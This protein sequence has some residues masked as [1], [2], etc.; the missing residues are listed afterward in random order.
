MTETSTRPGSTRD[1]MI[2]PLI[3]LLA[4]PLIAFNFGFIEVLPGLLATILLVAGLALFRLKTP[5]GPPVD[6]RLLAVCLGVGLV[7]I[8]LSGAGHFLYRTDDWSIRDAVLADLVAHPWPFT[9]QLDDKL[10]MIR[11]PLGMYLVPALAG[12][13][14]GLEAADL[15]MGVQNSLLTGLVLYFF[16][17]EASTWRNRII[18]LVVFLLFHGLSV[19]PEL[20]KRSLLG[21]TFE[22]LHARGWGG[23]LQYSFH[24]TQLF[25]VPNHG[26]AG[27]SVAAVYVAWRR[28]EADLA[29]LALV[30]ALALFWSPLAIMGG[31]LLFGFSAVSRWR[32][33]IVRLG[34]FA[35]P[36]LVGL[37]I[38]PVFL[39]MTK[40]VGSLP[41]GFLTNPLLLDLYGIKILTE[42]LPFAIIV[43][44]DRRRS[45]DLR[46][47]WELLGL[48]LAMLLFPFYSIGVG[49]DFSRRAIIPIMA[50]LSLGVGTALLHALNE[51]RRA[52]LVIVTILLFGAV[53]P[54]TEIARNLAVPASPISTCNLLDARASGPFRKL[55]LEHY[56]VTA[57]AFT[58]PPGLFRQPAADPVGETGRRCWGDGQRQFILA[59]GVLDN[60]P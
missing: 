43:W 50:V 11:A 52:A 23:P 6:R 9:Y 30:I 8:L 32:D 55:G 49:D 34:S 10:Q 29:S 1:P 42:V 2:F 7:A 25:W 56:L 59:P 54:L 33:E 12:K 47:Q 17:R 44:L 20:L 15:V 38:V 46:G 48:T 5:S 14:W 51:R 16:A 18:I 41:S 3:L 27:W 40:S 21:E 57:T 19:F 4:A 60:D 39:F 26:L 36:V 35:G 13:L 53:S 45:I 37:G 22:L 28:R 58:T 31:I 24:I